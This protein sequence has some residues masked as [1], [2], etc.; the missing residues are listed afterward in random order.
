MAKKKISRINHLKNKSFDFVKRVRKNTGVAILAAFAFII[1]FAWR[2]AIQESVNIFLAK[3]GLTG[4]TYWIKFAVAIIVTVICVF[5][6]MIFS[7]WTEKE[8]P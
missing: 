5:G 3:F 4:Q 7:R 1:A 6:I 8:N 2:D